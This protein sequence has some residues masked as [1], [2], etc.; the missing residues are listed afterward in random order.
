ML[1]LPFATH[2]PPRLAELS[3][4]KLAILAIQLVQTQELPSV[5][6]GASRPSAGCRTSKPGWRTIRAILAEFS[7]L[8]FANHRVVSGN[9]RGRHG[10]VNAVPH[11]A[12]AARF[13]FP[14]TR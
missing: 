2:S 13:L 10:R 11:A 14:R 12:F 4:E 5:P 3:R 7:H 8:M 6:R 1:R 9:L